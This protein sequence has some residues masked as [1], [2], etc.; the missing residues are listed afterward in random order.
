MNILLVEDEQSIQRLATRLLERAG[1][2]VACCDSAEQAIKL[3]ENGSATYDLLVTDMVLPGK[4]GLD[5]V[6]Q[7]PRHLPAILMSGYSEQG[8]PEKEAVLDKLVFL[9]KPFSLA[10][11]ESK[12]EEAVGGPVAGTTSG[13]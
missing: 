12:I 8:L 9:E 10:Q 1:H 6:C 13:V 11:F 5:L 7:V 4:S 3:L 2:R